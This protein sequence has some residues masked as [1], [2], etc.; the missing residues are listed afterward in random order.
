VSA[1][2]SLHGHRFGVTIAGDVSARDVPLLEVNDAVRPGE[3]RDA[4]EGAAT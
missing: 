3:R 1:T 2:E 4:V